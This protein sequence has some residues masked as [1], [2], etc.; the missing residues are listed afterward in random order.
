MNLPARNALQFRQLRDALAGALAIGF[1]G[2][3]LL[4]WTLDL[5]A[6][7]SVLPGWVAVKPNTALGF[8]LIG[9][10]L[11]LRALPPS[12]LNPAPSTI[13][14]RLARLCGWLAGLV[15]VLT[16][17]EYAFGWNPGFD[18]WLFPEPA[19]SVGT[20]HPGRMAPDT[21]LCFALL[22]ASLEIPL[23]LREKRR[24]LVASSILG[25]LVTTVALAAIVAY[26]VPYLRTHGWWGLTIMASPTAAMFALLGATIVLGSWREA[27]GP[28]LTQFSDHLWRMAGCAGALAIA[29][30]LY[31]R[32]EMEIAHVS[33]QRYRSV[34]LADELRQSGDD[35]TRMARTYVVTGDPVYK[36]RF[37]EILDIRDGKKP[38]P[39][40]YWRPYW[41]LVLGNGPAPRPGRQSV[42]LLDLMRQAG[43]TEQEFRKLAE[44][45]ANSDGLTKPEFEA[46]KLVESTGP[47]AEANRARAR[48]LM[49]DD[50]YHQAKASV[51]GPIHDFLVLVDQRTLA[52]VQAA[53]RS[54]TIFRCAV[55]AFGL[56]LLLLLW[57]AYVALCDTLGGSVDE[58]H[59]HI[60][61]IGSGDFSA[62][63]PLK[64]N[65]KNSVLAWLSETQAKLKDT[66][67]E[68]QRAEAGLRESES[69]FRQLA[70]SLPQLVW[71]CR[72][73][74]P[75][76]Y[77]SPQWL[78]FTA[79][80]EAQQL[81][82]GWLNQIHPDDRAGLSHAWN[83]A[84]A[85]G[86]VFQVEF[87]I[88]RHDGVYRWFDTRAVPLRDESGKIVKWFGTNTDITERKRAGDEVNQLNVELEQRVRDRTATLRESEA[89]L[90]AV[91][92]N[93]GDLVWSVDTAY[94]LTV[95][96]TAF[97]RQL[98]PAL[99]REIQ[100]GELVLADVFPADVLRQ[101]R[102][103]YDRALRGEVF[104]AETTNAEADGALTFRENTFHPISTDGAA[105]GVACV[106]RD[107]TGRKQVEQALR[108]SEVRY[109]TLAETAE[110]MIY[111]I[112]REFR[113]E[114]VIDRALCT[115]CQIS[116]D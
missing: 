18:Q 63:I 20:S 71:T 99:G 79:V 36:Q 45:K 78:G 37:Q 50:K 96:N 88:R 66:D 82:S 9:L 87:R 85:S 111:L 105:I 41:D 15:G 26:A 57:R 53:E 54:T 13:R 101:W 74:G 21:A 77:L 112:N 27:L 2:I 107:I 29:I 5:V 94:R 64:R 44:A 83:A 31:A 93:T 17:S 108:A 30:A 16:L 61:R 67:R 8:V 97:R 65:L 11:L 4:G 10:A 42:A 55:A 100:N 33:E 14:S 32:S 106:S 103:F 12:T 98:L 7:K 39:E 35:L 22:A 73:D 102:G 47:E 76:D 84:V 81:G 56:G 80:P 59:E 52:A 72:P 110:E 90:L 51:M 115:R 23:L 68:R 109:R 75:C 114:Y 95:A 3:V 40:N 34:L 28:R 92:E 89:K 116:D 48:A 58:V 25:A 49:Y 69:R 6:L 70:G 24:G 1:G 104:L 60:A 62:A 86:G 91:I 43:F 19:G 38:R 113:V 46:M